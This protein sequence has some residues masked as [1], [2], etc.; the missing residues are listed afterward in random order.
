M[1]LP[2][3][4][5]GKKAPWLQVEHIKLNRVEFSRKHSLLRASSF[6]GPYY[7]H[8][9]S[10]K[11][12]LHFCRVDQI[13][14]AQRDN[15]FRDETV[16]DEW[17]GSRSGSNSLESAWFDECGEKD[18]DRG[19]REREG[20]DEKSFGTKT[21]NEMRDIWKHFEEIEDRHGKETTALNSHQYLMYTYACWCYSSL[22][23]DGGHKAFKTNYPVFE[24]EYLFPESGKNVELT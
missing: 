18:K 2:I 7:S 8:S 15:K 20:G 6:V 12:S 19:A 10:G 17:E 9:G 22:K 5:R 11:M 24:K 21:S 3:K 4:L 23:S 1:R 13:T 16:R 14:R